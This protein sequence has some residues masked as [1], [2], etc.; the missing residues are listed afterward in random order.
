LELAV[1]NINPKRNFL[2]ITISI[3]SFAVN[4]LW[5][6][7]NRFNQPLNID[8][9]GY[10]SISLLDYHQ[11]LSNGV[12]GWLSTVD[13]PSIQAPLTTAVTSLFYLVFGTNA[14]TGFIVISCFAVWVIIGTYLLGKAHGG[15]R[16]GVISSL[17]VASCPMFFSY[18]TDYI[19][20]IPTAAMTTMAL[21]S[22]VKSNSFTNMRYAIFF[23]LFAGAMLLARTM[24]IAFVPFLF[25]GAF[26]SIVVHQ[27]NL[28]KQFG[29]LL[30]AA[31]FA[32][33]IAAIW[34][35]PNGMLVLH[36]LTSYGYGHNSTGYANEHFSKS[37]A[38]IIGKYFILFQPKAW[39]DHLNYLSN[40]LYFPD[41]II[42]ISG[43]LLSLVSI[44]IITGRNGIRNGSLLVV[45]SKLFPI[46]IFLIGSFA[47]LVST[48][49]M[50][51]GFFVPLLPAI[52]VIF[53]RPLVMLSDYVRGYKAVVNTM[54]AIVVLFSYVP[55]I[56]LDSP[57]ARPWSINL[58]IFGPTMIT[59]GASSIEM[60]EEKT[61]DGPPNVT[62]PVPLTQGTKWIKASYNTAFTLRK[63]GAE[64]REVGFAFIN[65]LYNVNTIQYEQLLKSNSAFPVVQ[66]TPLSIPNTV[67]GYTQWLAYGAAKDCWFLLTDSGTK[68]DFKPYVNNAKMV[69]AATNAGFH[70]TDKW[71]LPNGQEVTMWFRDLSRK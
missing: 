59:S 66:I 64:K 8:E 33:M 69:L 44:L 21:L 56:S 50:G 10:L 67:A 55:H 22:L 13:G 1:E 15:F 29:L 28:K 23:G 6:G 61:G 31:I 19:F 2:L 30:L 63:N 25:L 57:L 60:Y 71:L 48:P 53:M 38:S 32:L 5:I 20:A 70:R 68:G 16:L 45:K 36:Y 34:F 62:V 27:E 18:E 26:A 47:A 12:Y 49:N 51:S 37:I 9:A 43:G 65:S 46:S 7:T 24:T 3:F 41:V 39:L 17:L 11:L 42:I 58:P 4:M 40:L 54:V 35:I 14:Y 52:I